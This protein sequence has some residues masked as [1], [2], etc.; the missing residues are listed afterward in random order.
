MN[1]YSN[2]EILAK[3]DLSDEELHYSSGLRLSAKGFVKLKEKYQYTAYTI[4]EKLSPRQLVQ[5]GHA[6]EFPYY[7]A[8]KSNKIFIFG[9][10]VNT[11][12]RLQGDDI[13]NWLDVYKPTKYK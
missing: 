1:G 12:I 9:E 6:L 10:N 3:Y 11:I 8:H 4:K 13:V 7:I 5:L 2:I